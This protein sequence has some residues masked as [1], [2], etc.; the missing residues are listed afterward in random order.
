MTRSPRASVPATTVRSSWSR[1][2]AAPPRRRRSHGRSRSSPRRRAWS[3]RRRCGSSNR[4][5]PAGRPWRS[6][7]STRR[8][9]RRRSRRRRCST[10]SAATVIPAATHGT[11]VTILVGGTTAIF[12]DFSHVLT[13][14]LPLFIGIVVVL[15]FLLLMV[16]FRS[17]LIPL[18]ASVMN[19][20][21]VARRVRRADRRLPGRDRQQADRPQHDRPDRVVHPGTPV[22]DPVRALDGL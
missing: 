1:K 4:R 8:A 20:L 5:V 12:E 17:L 18:T 19:L 21:S 10:T 16:V 22:P 13:G 9:R 15:S 11:G 3:A 14:K 6:P 2:S 7:T